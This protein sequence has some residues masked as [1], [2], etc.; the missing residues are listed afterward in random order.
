MKIGTRIDK[1]MFRFS[2]T[3]RNTDNSILF[4]IT[5][6]MRDYLLGVFDEDEYLYYR[7]PVVDKTKI[8]WLDEPKTD[9]SKDRLFFYSHTTEG[10]DITELLMR[11]IE[12]Y[13][14]GIDYVEDESVDGLVISLYYNETIYDG[15]WL[16]ITSF[17]K[18]IHVSHT[19]SEG[20][21]WRVYVKEEKPTPEKYAYDYFY[22]YH[23]LFIFDSL[24]SEFYMRF[25]NF[26]GNIHKEEKGFE[27]YQLDGPGEKMIAAYMER[28]SFFTDSHDNPFSKNSL[29][30]FLKDK[31][32]SVKTIGPDEL[33]SFFKEISPLLVAQLMAKGHL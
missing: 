21:E 24:A 18:V 22:L 8:L 25:Y 7:N 32:I 27:K 23:D 15:E 30:L 26:I 14:Q 1:G 29:Y 20:I 11:G 13:Y 4:Q 3:A 16:S 2:E 12:E 5:S 33:F 28:L 9:L 19:E 31:N 10:T 6:A 17:K